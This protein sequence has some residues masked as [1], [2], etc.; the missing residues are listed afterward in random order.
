MI[1]DIALMACNYFTIATPLLSLMISDTA[2][3][4]FLPKKKY[5]IYVMSISLNHYILNANT[6]LYSL[7]FFYS[8]VSV[9]M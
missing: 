8:A 9:F 4:V 6:S 1:S 2:I 3:M 5:S 7:L